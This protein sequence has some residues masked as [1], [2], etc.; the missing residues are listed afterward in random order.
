MYLVHVP[1]VVSSGLSSEEIANVLNYILAI[2][3]DPKGRIPSF[4]ARE[5]ANLRSQPVNDVVALRRHIVSR[6][7]ASG[8]TTA[9]Y[10][11]P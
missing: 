8:V 5:V 3:G 11:W 9:D 2:W 6:L 7:R 1:G 10:P 4:T